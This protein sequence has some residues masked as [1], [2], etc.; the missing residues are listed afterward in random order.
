MT[1]EILIN[2]M[3]SGMIVVACLT[4]IFLILTHHNDS[5]K[6]KMQKMLPHESNTLVEKVLKQDDIRRILINLTTANGYKDDSV[7]DLVSDI[8]KSTAYALIILAVGYILSLFFFKQF[9]FVCCFLS[10]YMVIAPLYN[11][12]KSK[13]AFR[14][15][16]IIDFNMFLNY[17]TL[18]LSGGVEMR[19]ALIEV[20][21]LLPDNS[22]VKPKVEEILAKNA[23][24][25][26]SG[27]SYIA[28]LEEF[29]KDLDFSEIQMF[30]NSAK[31][32]QERGDAIA[33]TLMMQIDDISKKVKM[34]KQDFINSRENIFGTMKIC[35]CLMPMMAAIVIPVFYTAV[36]M[37]S[38]NF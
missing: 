16:Y 14:K 35:L 17:I 26:L 9:L 15:K 7:D 34:Q 24:S 11:R 18:Y 38:M 10:I 5:K 27:N 32:S 33:E 1:R 28:T 30:I 13:K 8:L 20:E 19:T 12:Y 2:Y 37:L 36:L 31:R 3:T 23:I 6:K 29:N 25:G 4:V 22:Y 21:K